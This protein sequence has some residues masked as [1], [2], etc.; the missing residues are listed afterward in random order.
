MCIVLRKNSLLCSE[1]PML[2]MKF[3]FFLLRGKQTNKWYETA[4]KIKLYWCKLCNSICFGVDNHEMENMSCACS[5]LD[6]RTLA[7][8][9]NFYRCRTTFS[10]PTNCDSISIFW[11]QTRCS[12]SMSEQMRCHWKVPPNGCELARPNVNFHPFRFRPHFHC[13]LNGMR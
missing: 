4:T 10:S 1:Y 11:K 7:A 13:S 5:L 3:S 12:K 8:Y 9:V 2:Q 6:I